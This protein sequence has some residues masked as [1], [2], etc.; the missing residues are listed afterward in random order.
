MVVWESY[1]TGGAEGLK[2][3]EVGERSTGFGKSQHRETMGKPGLDFVPRGRKAGEIRVSLGW[4]ACY[5]TA[6]EAT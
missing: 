1:R 6:L 5:T 4:R 2:S 3:F